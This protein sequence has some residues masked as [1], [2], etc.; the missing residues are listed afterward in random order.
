[1]SHRKFWQSLHSCHKATATLQQDTM[2]SALSMS[3]L[4]CHPHISICILTPHFLQ[5]AQGMQG[6]PSSSLI[7]TTTLCSKVRMRASNWPKITHFAKQGL[8]LGHTSHKASAPAILAHWLPI[9]RK[10]L[11][12]VVKAAAIISITRLP[13]RLNI[14]QLLTVR[15]H[16]GGQF[17]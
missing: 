9:E 2:P 6:C 15:N 4:T 3:L 10:C 11:G 14:L 13:V 17:I 7:F 5:G 16:G 8:N 12:T 1:M